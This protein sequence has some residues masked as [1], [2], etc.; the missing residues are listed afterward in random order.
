MIESG[1]IPE[2][3]ELY[4]AAEEI[5]AMEESADTE[6]QMA[7]DDNKEKLEGN[8]KNSKKEI[9]GKKWQSKEEQKKWE[10]IEY[11]KERAVEDLNLKSQQIELKSKNSSSK[12]SKLTKHRC[13]GPC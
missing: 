13:L 4:A 12:P 11:L 5:I 2:H 7:T 6:L 8:G 1:I 9:R 3:N 10:A